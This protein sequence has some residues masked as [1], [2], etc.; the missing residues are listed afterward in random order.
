M[1]M[2]Y[3]MS[4]PFPATT[5]FS[6]M[7]WLNGLFEKKVHPQLP[8][9][10][11]SSISKAKSR[12]VTGT[13]GLSGHGRTSVV[14]RRPCWIEWYLSL[15]GH[16]FMCKVDD[17]YIED[18]FNLTRLNEDV[19]HFYNEALEMI[20]DQLDYR[21]YDEPT[22]MAIEKA[23]QHL[24]GLIHARYILTN[25]GMT[26][27]VSK[28]KKGVFGT[29]PRHFCEQQVLLP[30]GLSDRPY[31][32]SVKL[33]CPRCTDVFH[34]MAADSAVLDGAYFGT[35][36]PHLLVQTHQSTIVPDT[37][38]ERYTPRIFGFKLASAS[39]ASSPS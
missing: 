11:V 17:F 31:V 5:D 13:S 9:S 39:T 2:E 25:S 34:C 16:D 6:F 24:Y 15:N 32:K 22:R 21:E 4:L 3:N 14:A 18:R 26:Q 29:C 20:T 7:Q 33:Y 28:C 30:V 23:A 38:I 35:T 1:T 12:S 10:S 19:P 8:S 37:S 27:M 36:F